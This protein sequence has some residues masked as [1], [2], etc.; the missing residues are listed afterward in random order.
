MSAPSPLTQPDNLQNDVI[1]SAESITKVFSGTTALDGVNFKVYRGKVNVLVGE[2]GAGKSTLM[3]I[4]AG[5]E[6]P[7]FGRLLVDGNEVTFKNTR[8]ASKAGVGIIYQELNLFP[9]LNI[10]ENIFAGREITRMDVVDH[11]AQE[12]L[13]RKIL[14]RLEQPLNPRTLVS[15][16]RMGQQQIVEIAKALSQNVRIL[17]M[18]EP[19]SALTAAETEALFRIIKHLKAHGVAIIYISHKLEELLTIGDYVTILRDGKLAASAPARSVNIA[20]II[21]K[22]VGRDVNAP[23]HRVRTTVGDGNQTALEI[24]DLCL[25]R[26]GGGFTL[27]N[28]SFKLM[29]GEILAIF[30]LMGAGR[31]ELFECIMG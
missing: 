12:K 11:S 21:D 15:D 22:M 29:R 16:L 2:N 19:T 7:T 1:L 27:E 24:K 14:D 23:R 30:G 13:A 5:V 26:V 18:D 9:N 4:L 8:E 6:P 3:K 20:W 28:V 10:A 25:P 31:T 17:I